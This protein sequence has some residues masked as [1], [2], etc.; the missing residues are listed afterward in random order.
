MTPP[1][2][3]Q[4]PAPNTPTPPAPSEPKVQTSTAIIQTTP[5]AFSET[6]TLQLPSDLKTAEVAQSDLKGYELPLL[7]S[8][9]NEA[10]AALI[11]DGI[12]KLGIEQE[13]SF[14]A[15]QLATTLYS[16]LF[17]TEIIGTPEKQ[18]EE[19]SI[20]RL[21]YQKKKEQ[22]EVVGVYIGKDYY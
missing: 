1:G 4:N 17:A 20:G 6:S 21:L 14:T 2:T 11:Y 16:E 22:F 10:H 19:I 15:E 7:S 18:A 9:E 8:F 13:E 5:E 3:I 12:K